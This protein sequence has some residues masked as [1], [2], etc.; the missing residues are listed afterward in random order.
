MTEPSK[1]ADGYTFAV[2]TTGVTVAA[3][4]GAVTYTAA[5]S[6]GRACASVLSTTIEAT[7]A[8]VGTGVGYVAGPAAGAVVGVGSRALAATVRDG[9][10]TSASLS[11]GAAAI[12]AGTGTALAFTA[13]S[14]AT[15]AGAVAGTKIAKNVRHR[16]VTYRSAQT[17]LGD[18][19]AWKDHEMLLED[20]DTI[21]LEE[22]S[23][24]DSASDGSNRADNVR[25]VITDADADDA[26]WLIVP[27]LQPKTLLP[28]FSNEAGAT[29][30][31]TESANNN[32]IPVDEPSQALHVEMEAASSLHA[33]GSASMPD[34]S[35]MMHSCMLPADAYPPA[36]RFTHG[37][38]PA[39]DEDRF[40]PS[41][42]TIDDIL[43]GLARDAAPPVY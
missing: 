26:A 3:I 34:E 32:D 38:A 17:G 33:H 18:E 31:T 30:I 19:T 4:V 6:S 42:P 13:G 14:Y 21:V 40:I 37:S 5:N 8:V 12:I 20:M 25:P 7:G 15:R 39:I 22:D 41:S 23:D 27:E 16:Y 10:N 28:P 43:D 35:V 1:E 36:V 9:L 2:T 29:E 24:R 11:A